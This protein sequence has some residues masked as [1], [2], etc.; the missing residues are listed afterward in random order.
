MVIAHT[1]GRT[2]LVNSTSVEFLFVT[3]PMEEEVQEMQRQW[4]ACSQ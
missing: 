4:S 1:E 3:T 2:R